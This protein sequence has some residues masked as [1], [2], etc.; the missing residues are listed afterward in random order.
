MYHFN[1]NVYMFCWIILF[2]YALHLSLVYKISL[3]SKEYF[4]YITHKWKVWLFILATC[5]IT[6]LAPISGDPTWDYVDSIFMSTLTYLTAPWAIGTIYKTLKTKKNYAV[7]YVAVC[8]AMFSSSWS[9]DAW[10]LYVLGM[11][12]LTW[13]SNIPLSLGMYVL[14]GMVW[15][16]S[17]VKNEG[18]VFAFRKTNW[19]KMDSQFK[20]LWGYVSVLSSVVFIELTSFIIFF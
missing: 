9:Y 2:V 10:M 15:N 17:W 11:Y 7:M 19:L 4:K 6:A 1:T 20:Y 14:A 18:V 8:F 16:L 3:Y 5:F 13:V 12:P